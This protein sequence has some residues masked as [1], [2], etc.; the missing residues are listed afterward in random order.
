MIYILFTGAGNKQQKSSKIFRIARGRLHAYRANTKLVFI[1]AKKIKKLCRFR[2]GK[3]VISQTMI[4]LS[5][6]IQ[7]VILMLFLIAGSKK[8]TIT[9]T[10]SGSGTRD[11]HLS[12]RKKILSHGLIRLYPHLRNSDVE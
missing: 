6:H 5:S 10:A 4:F 11:I 12:G 1:M 9:E 3:P 7:A 2:F 8:L